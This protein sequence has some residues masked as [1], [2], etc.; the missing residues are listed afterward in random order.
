ML[1]CSL[2]ML[3][4]SFSV[5]PGTVAAVLS[6]G[7]TT[8][9]V[10]GNL[11]FCLLSQHPV[12]VTSLARVTSATCTALSSVTAPDLICLFWVI[13]AIS[14]LRMEGR[15]TRALA[16]PSMMSARLIRPRICAFD[17]GEVREDSVVITPSSPP[18]LVRQ[19]ASEDKEKRERSDGDDS[20]SSTALPSHM[21]VEVVLPKNTFAADRRDCSGAMGVDR[22]KLCLHAVGYA[23]GDSFKKSIRALNVAKNTCVVP[24]RSPLVE[25]TAPLFVTRS[26]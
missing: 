7:V 3:A 9:V 24:C 20:K 17:M 22:E 4:S 1:T 2:L 19:R 8:L 10:N 25:S 13:H 26:M 5:R 16:L 15:G 11:Q 21:P 6:A 18:T 12:G 14:P 23:V